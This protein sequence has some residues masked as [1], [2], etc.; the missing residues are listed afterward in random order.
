[1]MKIRTAVFLLKNRIFVFKNKA[2]ENDIKVQKTA[3]I[4]QKRAPL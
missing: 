4:K 2:T 3:T 1:M